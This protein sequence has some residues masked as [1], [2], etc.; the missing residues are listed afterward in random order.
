[1]ILSYLIPLSS[2]LPNRYRLNKMANLTN[3]EKQ[4]KER[5]QQ[6]E[7]DGSISGNERQR[8]QE[9]KQKS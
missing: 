5:L 1:M 6:K 7:N 2:W 9:L 8:L 4:E 3:E